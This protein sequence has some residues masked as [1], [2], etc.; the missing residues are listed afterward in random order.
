MSPSIRE[1]TPCAKKPVRAVAHCKVGVSD[2]KTHFV[3]ITDDQYSDMFVATAEHL[4]QTRNVSTTKPHAKSD[5]LEERSGSNISATSS[6]PSEKESSKRLLPVRQADLG[7]ESW[8]IHGALRREFLGRMQAG[9][10]VSDLNNKDMLN[11]SDTGGQPMFHEVLPV[12][13]RNTMIGILTVKLNE[14]LDSH[15]LVEYYMNG[16][17][18]GEP[19]ES[20]LSHFETFRH[21]MRV[22]QSTC[23][24]DT[25]PKIAFVGTHKD[26]EH[27]CLSLIHI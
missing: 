4:P 12:F 3:R 13:I 9:S 17:P 7:E 18:I 5:T 2:D 15:P 8:C 1:S 23:E 19:F 11:V 14:S 6:P 10:K 21:C 25:C 26:L 16:K 24:P 27:E 22:I 20:L